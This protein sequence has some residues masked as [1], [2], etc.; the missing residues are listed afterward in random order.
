[1]TPETLIPGATTLAQL[2]RI[3]RTEAPVRLDPA[4]RPGVDWAAAQIA[5]AAAGSAAV[6][7]VNTGFG[8]LSSL[9]IAPQ[10][11]A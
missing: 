4:A 1:M 5:K 9:K 7:G 3:Y 2:E 10:D 11:T 8:K 6:Y